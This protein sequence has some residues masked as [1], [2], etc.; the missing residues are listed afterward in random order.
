MLPSSGKI[1]YSIK[2]LNSPSDISSK[3]PQVQNKGNFAAKKLHQIA[4]T[5]HERFE[6]TSKRTNG[7]NEPVNQSPLRAIRPYSPSNAI[8]C[9]PTLLFKANC[10]VNKE[11]ET[12]DYSR[13]YNKSPESLPYNKRR[14]IKFTV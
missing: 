6:I 7:V 11:R 9:F 8:V 2:S 3:V 5:L 12:G 4:T 10:S 14:R 13:P 1:S